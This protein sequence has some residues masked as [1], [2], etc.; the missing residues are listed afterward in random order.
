[1]K[2][3]N[4]VYRC[5]AAAALVISSSALLSLTSCSSGE[6]YSDLLNDENQDVN[7]FL[8][9]QLVVAN[10]PETILNTE[11]TLHIT[12]STMTELYI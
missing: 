8:A 5:A 12:R 10:G 1:M 6:S 9:D 11:R 4:I 3:T 7:R 2:L